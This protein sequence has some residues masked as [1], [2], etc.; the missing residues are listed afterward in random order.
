MKPRF[1][2]VFG[3]SAFLGP[4]AILLWPELIRELF[5]IPL[6]YFV[7]IASL[8]Y[9]SFDQFTLWVALILV[10]G[11]FFWISLKLRRGPIPNP[12]HPNAQ[13]LSSVL[14]WQRHLKDAQRGA[15]MRWRLAQH[16]ADLTDAALACRTGL[17]PESM[18]YED[19]E[20]PAEIEAYLR[21]AK[22]FQTGA[23]MSRRW[24]SSP[25][26]QPLNLPPEV[27]VAYIEQS[28]TLDRE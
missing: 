2:W 6:T 19:L 22:K 4:L 23:A 21:T 5:V 25:A 11:V 10:G 1:W 13:Q 12:V 3:A 9:L 8:L 28:L 15:Y 17:P 27:L 26:P 24:F 18:L 7:G 20:L 14:R 16:I